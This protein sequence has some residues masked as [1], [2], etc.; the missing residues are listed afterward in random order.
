MT[1]SLP[2]NSYAIN[3]NCYTWG[4]FDLAECLAQIRQTPIRTVE[5]PAEQVRPNSL[6]PELMFDAPL[7]GEWRYS[8]PDLR[9][10]LAQDGFMVDSLD[11]FGYTGYPG[12]A[13][14]I[15]RRID[16]A[17][18][19]EAGIIV[20]GCHHKALG[21]KPGEPAGQESQ[22]GKEARYFAYAMLREV[23]DYAADRGV[24]LALEIHA[25]VM[26]N[27]AEA[28]RTLEE[29]NRENLGVNFDTA[30]ILYYNE[31]LD[32]A[33]GAEALATLADRV[34]HVH[35]KDIVRGKTR[36]EHV[37]PRLGEGEVDFRKVF[38]I[39]HAVG[40]YGPFSFEVET[41]HGA[42]ETD[43]ISEYHADVVASI[44]YIRS[45]GEFPGD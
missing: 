21:H 33:G 7:G 45:L 17:E 40:F 2:G 27:T 29:V 14:F 44:E 26:E 19:L 10:L 24:E 12:A 39:L 9:Q 38:E 31:T 43:D 32:A 23:A 16:L 6:V 13:E 11:V 37:L 5:L 30:N 25:G 1:N 41:F 20:L 22:E 35:L 42:T 18:A 34:F 15:K 36:Q 3:M 8:L 28:L 4:R